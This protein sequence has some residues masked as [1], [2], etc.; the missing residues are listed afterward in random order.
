MLQT[1]GC[2]LDAH[3]SDSDTAHNSDSDTALW[4]LYNTLRD[5]LT[6]SVH[7]IIG[8]TVVI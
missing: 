6:A 4:I 3:N 7:L 5:T 2:L 8:L 1:P